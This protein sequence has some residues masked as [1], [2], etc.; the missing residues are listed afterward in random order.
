MWP[1]RG[2]LMGGVSGCDPQPKVNRE[3]GGGVWGVRVQR[4]PA[5][6]HTIHLKTT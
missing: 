2:S 5:Y 3:V 4:A 1:V 6:K